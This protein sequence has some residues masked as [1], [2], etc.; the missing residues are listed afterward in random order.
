M[1]YLRSWIIIS[2][3][4]EFCVGKIEIRVIRKSLYMEIVSNKVKNVD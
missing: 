3:F 2:N 4:R 1:Y